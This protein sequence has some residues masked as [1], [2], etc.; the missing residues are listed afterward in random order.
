MY[1]NFG[2]I[3][4]MFGSNR[5]FRIS[6]WTRGESEG[7]PVAPA[8]DNCAIK[9]SRQLRCIHPPSVDYKCSTLLALRRAEYNQ[10]MPVLEPPPAPGKQY[11]PEELPF[12]QV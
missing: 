9:N 11:E 8:K 6:D 7:F 10:P 12:A 4:P 5:M 2:S 1:L 3:W